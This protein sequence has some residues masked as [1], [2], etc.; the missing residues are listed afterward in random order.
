MN[1]PGCV[2]ELANREVRAMIATR[3]LWKVAAAAVCA[4][5]AIGIAWAADQ[6]TPP[7]SPPTEPPVTQAP[8][9][10]APEVPKA[11][12]GKRL[13]FRQL[14][15]TCNENSCRG[16]NRSGPPSCSWMGLG[17]LQAQC[18]RCRGSEPQGNPNVLKK[19]HPHKDRAVYF[20]R[21]TAR[22]IPSTLM[23]RNY[24]ALGWM[25]LA[26]RQDSEESPRSDRIGFDKWD[27]WVTPQE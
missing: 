2:L 11:V 17:C 18:S 26:C 14:P 24:C 8:R 25:G 10:A 27:E 5:M 15:P 1:L 3:A 23:A 13:P 12:I 6:S 7:Q 16:M 22:A 9:G 19:Y 21:T 4:V 20:L